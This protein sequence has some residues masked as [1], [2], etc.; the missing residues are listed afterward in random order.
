MKSNR[1][2][3]LTRMQTAFMETFGVG[4]AVAL[5]VI[6]LI[7]FVLAFAVYWFFHSA[8]PSSLTI[9]SGP[10]GS[11]FQ[12]NAVKFK[13]ILARNGVKL[14]ILASKGSLENLE[15][16][17]DPSFRVDIGFV[18]GGMATGKNVEQ[19]ASLGSISYEPLLIFYR[20]TDSHDLL[21]GLKGKTLAV[22]ASG[23]GTRAL[24]A[25]LLAANGIGTTN[26]ADGTKLLETE[27]DEGAR[28]LVEGSADAVFLTSDSAS[29]ELMRGLLQRSGIRLFDFSQAEAYSRRI[30]YLSELKLPMG[31][32]DFGKNIPAKDIHLVAP[33]VQLIARS[34]LH[35]ALS[36]LLIEAAS[37]IYGGPGIFKNRGDFPAPIE[38]E[39][40]I[41]ADAN[42]YYKSGKSFLY[43]YL[44]FWM[45]SMVSRIL[46]VLVPIVVV[47][48]PS[49]RVF[50]TLLRMRVKLRIYKWYRALL[51]VEQ[52]LMMSS[53]KERDS[54]RSEEL[55]RRLDLIEQEVNR[56]KVPASF[57]DQ[58][59]VLRGHIDFVRG[60]LSA[61][62]R[63]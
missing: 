44:P 53:G 57:A 33:T 42:R 7:S 28:A 29:V 51:A 41:S 18:Q 11:I 12:N 55:L 58:F 32:I 63:N 47:V 62:V 24:A 37:E 36:D 17:N 19:L 14:N 49:V 21:S 13:T 30:T 22:G 54:R 27:A 5:G 26:E 59:Y 35:P 6:V 4:R 46:V 45:A 10:A 34:D 3:S 31:S 8:P 39:F 23:S 15:R 60:R 1:K 48:I 9:T 16:L 61:G 56:M 43:R 25:A 38:Q 20:G 50:P 52:E 40:R 2:I